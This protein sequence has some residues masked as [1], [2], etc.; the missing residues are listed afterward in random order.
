MDGN[1]S[2]FTKYGRIHA[3]HLIKKNGKAI[4][5]FTFAERDT[6]DITIVLYGG[7]TLNWNVPK[8]TRRVRDFFSSVNTM[9][10][11]P[12][13]D[14][15]CIR[16]FRDNEGRTII[17]TLPTVSNVSRWY[18]KFSYAVPKYRMPENRMEEVRNNWTNELVITE[19]AWNMLDGIELKSVITQTSFTSLIKDT[20]KKTEN[21]FLSSYVSTTAINTIWS[22]IDVDRTRLGELRYGHKDLWYG[23][24]AR[25]TFLL[26]R[27]PRYACSDK[28]RMWQ[29]L[30][31]YVVEYKMP[32]TT[33]LLGEEELTARYT[34]LVVC[35]TTR[36]DKWEMFD[37][38]DKNDDDAK[39]TNTYTVYVNTKKRFFVS[40]NG[41][42]KI[43][44]VDK[45]N[46]LPSYVS[47]LKG[48]VNVEK[49]ESIIKRIPYVNTT[50]KKAKYYVKQAVKGLD[51]KRLLRHNGNDLYVYDFSNYHANVIMNDLPR[52]Y[53]ETKRTISFLTAA[54]PYDSSVKKLLTSFSGISKYYDPKMFYAIRTGSVKNFLRLVKKNEKNVVGMATDSVFM[55]SHDLRVPK[56]LKGRYPIKL[57]C[58]LS[59]YKFVN[60][61]HYYGIDA[62]SGRKI[63]KGF[64]GYKNGCENLKAFV[65]ALLDKFKPDGIE[66]VNYT[67]FSQN[68]LDAVDAVDWTKEGFY[69]PY[70]ADTTASSQMYY[71]NLQHDVRQVYIRD[72]SEAL[73]AKGESLDEVEAGKTCVRT[74]NANSDGIVSY[75]VYRDKMLEALDVFLNFCLKQST[76]QELCKNFT[77]QQLYVCSQRL[78][79]KIHDTMGTGVQLI[80]AGGPAGLFV[81]QYSL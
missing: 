28:T 70:T 26:L 13:V 20:H 5:S 39:L 57:E 14:D 31:K 25:D 54:R 22:T 33:V 9:V 79:S 62:T 2:Y 52:K 42:G 74:M 48:D 18:E 64:P 36:N 23:V 1:T 7:H 50:M 35:Y 46:K 76:V 66:K 49:D 21:E 44:S 41:L 19:R 51:K 11:M 24:S 60:I 8:K 63:I 58:R 37:H 27:T 3:Y 72:Y 75:H 77:T 10:P 4:L 68:L 69:V 16:G 34:N 12:L 80:T 65:R 29:K 59:K 40:T 78:L 47:K 81:K 17:K 61:D 30:I 55:N 6:N 56:R 73:Y 45:M 32:Y 38:I 53:R 15:V 67:T 43:E 71:Q